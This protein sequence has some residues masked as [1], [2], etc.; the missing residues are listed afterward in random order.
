MAYFY[1]GDKLF[2]IIF[3]I[4]L[5]FTLFANSILAVNV[6]GDG[7]VSTTSQE[8]MF[9]ITKKKARQI[10]EKMLKLYKS[11]HYKEAFALMQKTKIYNADNFYFHY[12][13]AQ[14][15]K[16][17]G[18]YDEAAQAFERALILKGNSAGVRFELAKMYIE[19]GNYVEAKILILNIIEFAANDEVKRDLEK[20]LSSI[21]QRNKEHYFAIFARLSGGTET[22]I[23][24]QA[25]D[26]YFVYPNWQ[27]FNDIITRY[28]KNNTL[29]KYSK[30]QKVPRSNSNA[31]SSYL[32]EHIDLSYIYRSIGSNFYWRAKLALDKKDALNANY[33]YLRLNYKASLIW[34]KRSF[35]LGADVFG[36]NSKQNENSLNE[37][38]APLLDR[39][40]TRLSYTYIGSDDFRVTAYNTIGFN[41][42]GVEK[43]KTNTLDLGLLFFNSFFNG[44]ISNSFG[45]NRVSENTLLLKK[46]EM[47]INKP[48]VLYINDKY[49][50]SGFS[51]SDYLALHVTSATLIFANI[52]FGNNN[53]K[54]LNWLY[55]LFNDVPGTPGRYE[56]QQAKY[57]QDSYVGVYAGFRHNYLN[58]FSIGSKVGY[59]YNNSNIPLYR[60]DN[61]F[62][63]AFIERKFNW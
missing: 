26:E 34:K 33:H 23:I 50:Y 46:Q 28:D 37:N 60:Y 8:E 61:F 22:N 59:Y 52:K 39:L 1:C 56:L 6:F 17:L 62:I 35:V 30:D 40:A 51:F 13:Y 29:L 14:C 16:N 5:F 9:S 45:V 32:S 57:R 48:S 58:Y 44:A 15:A 2:K 63:D 49:S 53:Y 24:N 27:Y 18:K 25:K 19:L 55:S 38:I 43:E 3:S 7:S 36:V 4:F 47:F 31:A 10:D 20:L 11:K 12:I 42:R 41:A 21:D 54:H